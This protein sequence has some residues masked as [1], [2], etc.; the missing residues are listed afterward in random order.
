LLDIG[1][2]FATLKRD[3]QKI[4]A[5]KMNQKNELAKSKAKADAKNNGTFKKLKVVGQ[6]DFINSATGEVVPMQVMEIEDRD[7]NFSKIWIAHILDAIEEIGS[8]KMK[9]LM[10]LINKRQTT[11][12]SIIATQEQIANDCK[13]SKRTVQDTLKA[14]EKHKVLARH[15][16][17]K[18]VYMLNPNVLFQGTH[19]K[20]MNVLI[21]YHQDHQMSLFEQQEQEQAQEQQALAVEVIEKREK[22]LA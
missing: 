13:V 17:V 14:L 5:K 10:H 19:N 4:G 3:P 6:Q 20:R 16:A 15:R 12:N 7:A 11:D 1:I 21:K 22:V 18:G 8:A 2:L 9:V